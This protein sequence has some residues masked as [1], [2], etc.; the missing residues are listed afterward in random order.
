M[1]RD[2]IPS[3][4]KD[5][6][7]WAQKDQCI[8]CSFPLVLRCHLHHIIAVK[9]HGP[10]HSLNLV[11][12]CAN[13]HGML[14]NLRTTK[15]LPISE[16]GTNKPNV[17]KWIYKNSAALK[18]FKKLDPQ[19]LSMMNL[20]LEPYFSTND[21]FDTIFS[22]QTPVIKVA[23]A[24]MIIDRD[25]ELLDGI[26]SKRLRIFSFPEPFTMTRR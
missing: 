13:H 16:L 2:P 22:D 26:N 14:E 24:R 10:D 25:I 5:F 23:I 21:S 8:F 7:R 15:H 12:L 6:V 11:G 19:S 18:E 9:D 20:L 4:T 3:Q 17:R 1:A